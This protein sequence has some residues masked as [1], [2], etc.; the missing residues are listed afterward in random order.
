MLKLRFGDL[1]KRI[2]AGV[3]VKRWMTWDTGRSEGHSM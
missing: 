1:E 2:M 3:A